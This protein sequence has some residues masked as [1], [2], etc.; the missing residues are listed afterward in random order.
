ME[1]KDY[2]KILGV[3]KNATE[4][5]IKRAYRKLARQY[6]PDVNPGD[7]VAEERFKEINEAYEVLS[8]PEKRKKYDQFGAQ[9]QQWQRMG[10]RPEDFD[11]SQ[12]VAQGTGPGG[13]RVY[14]HTVSP[15]E[16]EEILGGFGGFSDFFET[17][18]GG[19]GRRRTS[20]F[21]GGPFDSFRA[22][23]RARPRRGRDIEQPVQIT[24][25]EAYR[26]T[27][28]VLQRDNGTRLEVKI[29]RGVKTGSRVRMAGKGIP[30]TGGGQAGDLYLKIE[31]LPHNTFERRGDDLYVEVPVDLYTCILGGETR[32]P[33][34]DG[35]VMLTIPPE[36]PNGKVFRLRGLGMPNLRNPDRHG[37]L[38]ATVNVQ[39][40]QHL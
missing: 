4:K 25:E 3:S 34:L 2:Y 18:F 12:W 24:L 15:E 28:R 8:D 40:P 35:S 33:T 38:Y 32:V 13:Q 5:E 14:T 20:D 19:M 1:Y 10:G 22:G 37:D 31:V 29:P 23:F 21:G 17:L 27:T 16:F 6:H 11:W 26:G 30:G 7:K 9:W 39:L 36:T